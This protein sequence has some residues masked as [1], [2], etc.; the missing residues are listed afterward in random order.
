MKAK[1]CDLEFSVD[2]MFT[3]SEIEM[4]FI[5]GYIANAAIFFYGFRIKKY[6]FENG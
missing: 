3:F 1:I 5:L 4:D 6:H 2:I